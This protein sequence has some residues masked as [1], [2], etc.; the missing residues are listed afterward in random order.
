MAPFL[1]LSEAT[2]VKNL[3][4]RFRVVKTVTMTLQTIG[5]MN[6][7]RITIHPY[8]SVCFGPIGEHADR[9]NWRELDTLLVRLR[10]SRSIR[11]QF[12][13][14]PDEG[15]KDARDHASS[16]LPELT[17][18]GIVDLVNGDPAAP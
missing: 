1:D 7:G 6:L 8:T 13:Y 18:T 10:T 12:I 3:A 16:L 14:G 17:K 11:L 15:W 9:Q 2:K 5:S 4:F